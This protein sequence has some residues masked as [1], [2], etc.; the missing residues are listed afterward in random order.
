MGQSREHLGTVSGQSQYVPKNGLGLSWDY[1]G[2]I[3]PTVKYLGLGQSRDGLRT[4]TRLGRDWD[5]TKHIN[6]GLIIHAF[7]DPCQKM[8]KKAKHGQ[9]QGFINASRLYKY[10]SRAFRKPFLMRNQG[11]KKF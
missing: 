2:T 1:S 11:Y 9:K 5:R 6:R 8:G 3:I 10:R 4:G 7:K